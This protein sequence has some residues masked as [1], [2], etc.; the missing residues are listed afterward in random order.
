MISR[1]PLGISR[2]VS[3]IIASSSIGSKLQPTGRPIIFFNVATGFPSS[4]MPAIWGCRTSNRLSRQR[5]LPKAAESSGLE[6]SSHNGVTAMTFSLMMTRPSQALI[7]AFHS[8]PFIA[9]FSLALQF[10]KRFIIGL[11]FSNIVSYMASISMT[12]LFKV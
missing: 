9:S 11:Q 3:I 8:S 1:R 12:F 6:I 7:E 4:L 2:R 10:S 5:S